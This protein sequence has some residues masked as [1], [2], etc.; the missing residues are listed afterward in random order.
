[1]SAFSEAQKLYDPKELGAIIAHCSNYGFVYSEP[2]VFV[3]AYL[4]Y[5]DNIETQSKLELDKCD[6]WFI[7]IASGDLEK[8]FDVIPKKDYIAF[9]RFDNKLRVYDFER[10]R[11]RYGK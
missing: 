3:C 9:E 5:S 11:R 2:D 7:F 8:A 10:L 4:V 6:T 1:M